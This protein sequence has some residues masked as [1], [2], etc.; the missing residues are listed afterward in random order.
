V[1]PYTLEGPELIVGTRTLWEEQGSRRG[2]TTLIS[3]PVDLALDAP[4]ARRRARFRATWGVADDDLAVVWVGRLDEIMKGP[5]VRALL[6]AVD[7]IPDRRVRAVICGDGT[8]AAPLRARAAEINLHH[9][10]A[11]IVFTGAIAQPM[12]AYS[13]AD[14]QVGM[15]S[16]AARGLAYGVPLV[17]VGERGWSQP[18]TPETAQTLLRDSFWSPREPEDDPAAAL[19]THLLAVRDHPEHARSIGRFGRGFVGETFG[20]RAMAARLAE[21]YARAHTE[22]TVRRWWLDGHREVRAA[23][24]LVA[25]ALGRPQPPVG[26]TEYRY[27]L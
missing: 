19:A 16:S 6:D 26:D 17:V 21:V 25:R 13:A 7:L 27:A 4:N 10:S 23:R 12:D 24:S 3:P 18:F 2:R 15:G 1:S 11:R 20:L 5:A 9:G 22:Y 8:A 14:V